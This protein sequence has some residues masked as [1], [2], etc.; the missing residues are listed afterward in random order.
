[1]EWETTLLLFTVVAMCELDSYALASPDGQTVLI[2]F[3]HLHIRSLA[4]RYIAGTYPHSLKSRLVCIAHT[5]AVCLN[6]INVA[7]DAV[8]LFPEISDLAVNLIH[9]GFGSS[10]T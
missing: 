4:I 6:N 1:M 5:E 10:A 8:V 9:T 3:V 7:E 2:P